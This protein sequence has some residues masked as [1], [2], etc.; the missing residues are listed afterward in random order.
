MKNKTENKTENEVSKVESKTPANPGKVIQPRETSVSGLP[1]SNPGN[2]DSF[3][4]ITPVIPADFHFAKNRIDTALL[5]KALQKADCEAGQVRAAAR[6]AIDD[7]REGKG[8][9]SIAT[10][11]GGA[12]VIPSPS[13][14]AEL[15]RLGYLGDISTPQGKERAKRL[16]DYSKAMDSIMTGLVLLGFAKRRA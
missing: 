7:G 16:A 11:A 4:A 13:I 9:R 14:V 12:A 1:E 15:V 3:Q 10:V 2:P 8:I 5:V 6:K